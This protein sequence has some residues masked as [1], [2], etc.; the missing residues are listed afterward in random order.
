MAEAFGEVE[1]DAVEG[2]AELVQKVAIVATDS[3]GEGSNET[4]D[5]SDVIEELLTK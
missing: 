2:A 5:F 4:N 1:G 3:F